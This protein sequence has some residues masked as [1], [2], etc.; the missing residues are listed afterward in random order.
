MIFQLL[1]GRRGLGIGISTFRGVAGC[2]NDGGMW[3]NTAKREDFL[4]TLLHGSNHNVP[5]WYSKP[6][7]RCCTIYLLYSR[8]HLGILRRCVRMLG[9]ES[10]RRC[11]VLQRELNGLTQR[12]VLPL[13]WYMGRVFR[14]LW[15]F[16]LGIGRKLGISES[17]LDHDR[18]E[19]RDIY[20]EFMD[21]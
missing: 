16:D 4:L 13:T 20:R 19:N 6:N 10:W 17:C 18:G 15:M 12:S 14:G 1:L 3:D 7:G 8:F 21:S 11:R 5:M 2:W 9:V